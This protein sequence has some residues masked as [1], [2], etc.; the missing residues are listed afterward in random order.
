MG[1]GPIGAV[2]KL[3]DKTGVRLDEVELIEIN[4]AFAS[5]AIACIKEL[6][7][8]E[9][10]VN[11]NGGAIALGHPLG[12]T[13]AVLTTKAAYEM[14]GAKRKYAIVTMCVGGGEGSAALF[15]RP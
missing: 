4:E 14:Q 6:G 7:L 11:I 3:L 12:A 8:D 10:R 2:R 5:Q 9:S 15:E 1:F 13:G